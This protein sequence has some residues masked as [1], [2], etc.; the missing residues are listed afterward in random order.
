M[1]PL[2]RSP[3]PTIQ[4]PSIEQ[5]KTKLT[6]LLENAN[7]NKDNEHFVSMAGDMIKKYSLPYSIEREASGLYI[8][9]Q[10]LTTGQ[11]H[12][13]KFITEH[14]DTKLMLKEA[15][16]MANTEHEV[17]IHGETGTG[18][19]I[20]AKSMIGSRG[21]YIKA[22]NCAA[23][24]ENLLESELFGYKRG[25]FTGAEADRDG[26]IRA[27]D[28]GVMFMDEIG[29]MPLSLQAKCLRML[30]ER[31]IRKVG[32]LKD[33]PITC[34]FVFATHR[35]L[36]EMVKTGTFRRD[37]YARI[38]TL[39]LNIKNI[40]TERK[41]DVIPITKSLEGG[42]LLLAKYQDEL[43]N[44]TFDLSL[45]VRSLQQYVVRYNVLGRISI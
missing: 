18:K 40:H 29:D 17:L 22:I 3:Q 33:E 14:E 19:E 2:T 23:I 21:G 31:V 24:P 26:L 34:K 37:L 44:G 13:Q 15:Q 39:V 38:S 45:N 20:I 7:G 16:L 25:S 32:S 36:G 9:K 4:Q 30:Q 42:E 11:L 27:A 35:N 1:T 5:L 10:S 41:C 8:L 12:L 43:T 6:F 28:N